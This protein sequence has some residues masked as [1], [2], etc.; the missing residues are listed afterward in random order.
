MAPAVDD[1]KWRNV[2]TAPGST[3]FEGESPYVVMNAR[4]TGDPVAPREINP[5][6][7][8][9][10]EEIILHAMEREPFRRFASAEVMKAELE[11]FALV[12]MT[13]RS[14]RLQMP[15]IWNMRWHSARLY[16]FCILIPLM[17]L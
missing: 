4:V 5:E 13:D 11:D 15:K 6:I 14:E 7:S 1:I 9:E 17:I 12:R 16:I 8:P 2:A 3:P 10:L